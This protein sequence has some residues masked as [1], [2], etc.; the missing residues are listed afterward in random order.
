M[1][2][3]LRSVISMAIDGRRR[4]GDAHRRQRAGHLFGS[5]GHRQPTG[6]RRV[7]RRAGEYPDKFDGDQLADMIVANG[8]QLD[9][10]P[11][12]SG[13]S[14]LFRPAGT[15]DLGRAEPGGIRGRRSHRR[16]PAGSG[17]GQRG[18]RQHPRLGVDSARPGR[19]HVRAVATGRSGRARHDGR[20]AAGRARYPR[21]RRRQVA[22]SAGVD[23]VAANTATTPCR[24]YGQGTASSRPEY[25]RRRAGR[26]TWRGPMSTA[27]AGSND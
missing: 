8:R 15:P 24:S 21:R 20:C 1:P 22:G 26:K 19:R 17:G 16:Q 6:R 10:V 4:H 11:Q 7:E 23:I 2:R 13:Q 3:A 18:W 25:D 14:G 27:K 9:L 12:G 5:E